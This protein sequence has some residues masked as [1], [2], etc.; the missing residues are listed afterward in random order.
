MLGGNQAGPPPGVAPS[1]QV[2]GGGAP[3]PQTG[4]A[5][6]LIRKLVDDAKAALDSGDLDDQEKAVVLQC[7]T[8]LQK[9]LGTRQSQEESAMGTTPAH[10]A[11]GRAYK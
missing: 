9:I 5:T 8:A 10:K 4:D 1:I 7:A 3:G 6:T 11:M 2:G